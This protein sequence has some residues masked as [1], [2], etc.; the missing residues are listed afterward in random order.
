[1]VGGNLDLHALSKQIGNSAAMIDRHYSELTA[2]M[3]ADKS[4]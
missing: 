3:A 2:T 1:M 4:A